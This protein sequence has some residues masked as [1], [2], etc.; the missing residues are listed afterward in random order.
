MYVCIYIYISI[1]IYVYTYVHIYIDIDTYLSICLTL[2]KS[3]I[4]L[5]EL[6]VL[7]RLPHTHKHPLQGH[8]AQSGGG[9][10]RRCLVICRQR[11]CTLEGFR[12]AGGSCCLQ[13]CRVGVGLC[14]LEHCLGKGKWGEGW[15][16]VDDATWRVI[17]S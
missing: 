5:A 8:H 11:D 7:R 9:R 6:G 13:C 2:G 4:D 10:Q 12:R 17:M 15:K 16:R 1:S 14:V 3:R